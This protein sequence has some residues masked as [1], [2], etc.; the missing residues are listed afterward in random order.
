MTRKLQVG[1]TLGEVFSIYRAQAGVL[2]P[3]AFWIFL[4]VAIVDGLVGEELSLFG[5]V[6]LASTLAGTLYQGMVVTLVRDVQDGRR[7]MSM[8]EMARSVMPVLLPLF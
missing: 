6:L 7:D 8:G 5:L 2:L 1:E 3:L 4:A